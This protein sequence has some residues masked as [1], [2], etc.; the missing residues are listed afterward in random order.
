VQSLVALLAIV[1]AIKRVAEQGN[2]AEAGLVGA[3]GLVLGCAFVRRQRRRAVPMIDTG[4]FQARPVRIALVSSTLTFFAL[5]GTNVALAQY[6]Q[7]VIG[8]SPLQAGLWTVPSVL[9]YLAGTAFAPAAI[10]RFSRVRVLVVGL[11]VS[12]VGCTLFTL[13][14]A[15][16]P[17]DLAVIVTATIVFALG[18]A[19]VYTISTD[20]VV[21]NTRPER[22]GAASAVA[23]TGAELGGAL[24]IALLGSIGVTVYRAA[25][26]PTAGLAP[27]AFADARRTL[28]DAVAVAGT[29][30]GSGAQELLQR[31]HVAFRLEF[32]AVGGG[33][34]LTILAALVTVI[35]LTR[36]ARRDQRLD[37]A[38]PARVAR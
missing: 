31:A 33:A 37:T 19:P 10:F 14:L 2:L 6:L 1:Y 36:R 27:A 9:A 38:R 26:A 5:Y 34:A 22:A 35:V 4:L 23:E 3:F 11:L 32:A 21:S 20:L 8:L 24:G 15:G 28:G 18:L 7:L 29:L 13:V 25:M 16:G 30:S 17:G 12:A